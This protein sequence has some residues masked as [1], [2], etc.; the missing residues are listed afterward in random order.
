MILQIIMNHLGDQEKA[1]KGTLRPCDYF[2]IICGTSTGGLIAIL[3]GRLRL[4]T[5]QAIN[6]YLRLSKQIFEEEKGHGL[7]GTGLR[8]SK[9][10]E[11]RFSAQKLEN[12]IKEV[13]KRYSGDSEA[14]MYEEAPEQDKVCHAFVLAVIADKV[15]NPDPQRFTTYD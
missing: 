3:L 13:V 9:K 6:E 5:Q 10:G 8:I 1:A 4:T 15:N 11:A 2:D 7:L 12:A 14:K